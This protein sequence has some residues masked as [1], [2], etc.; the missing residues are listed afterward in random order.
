M[1]KTLKLAGIVVGA[2]VLMVA[3]GLVAFAGAAAFLMGLGSKLH[4]SEGA[5]EYYFFAHPY[6][7]P[8]FI[9]GIAALG[10]VAPGAAVWY[11]HKH[12]WR[13]KFRTLVIAV[14][15]LAVIFGIYA[16]SL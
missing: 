4:H 8:V 1:G 3:C 16:M 14:T 7:T 9:C 5:G 11:L 15:T 13:V 6:A 2:L 12:S 10:F